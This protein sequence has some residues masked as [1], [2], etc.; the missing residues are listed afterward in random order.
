MSGVAGRIVQVNVSK[1]GVP[2]LA[3]LTAP[4]T[5]NG[6]AGDRQK[7]LRYHGGPE[8]A[9]SC[10][11]LEVIERL[12][13]EGH[14]IA[15]G[16]TGEN[17][18]LAGL[19]WKRVQPG[20]R[21]RFG[22]GVELEVTSFAAPCPTIRR[23][24]VRGEFDRLSD[25]TH[26]GESRV[27]CRVLVEGE[28]RPGESVELLELPQDLERL[29]AAVVALVAQAGFEPTVQRLV[30]E[31]GTTSESFVWATVDLGTLGSEL[32]PAIRSAWIFVLRQDAPS[33][34]HFHPNSVQHMA[35]VRGQG[36][37]Q[38]GEVRRPVVAFDADAHGLPERW[39]VIPERVPHEFFPE[40][41]PMIVVSFHTCAADDLQEVACSSGVL[42]IYEGP[43]PR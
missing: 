18:T 5:R 19:D 29:Q 8:R 6:L 36:F 28:L 14:P 9:V 40:G 1:G 21:L 10:L 15:P 17:L 20:T 16:S 24:F 23:S 4:V 34:A 41:E 39:H 43:G 32:P 27:Y 35:M 12:A 7:D 2:K 33:G 3:V 22:G 37:S 13:R 31:L 11:A 25:K 38:V 26:P 42:R 30:R